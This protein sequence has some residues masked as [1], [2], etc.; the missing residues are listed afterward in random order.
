MDVNI[1]TKSLGFAILAMLSAGMSA[2]TYPDVSFGTT[3]VGEHV[4]RNQGLTSGTKKSK[5][6]IVEVAIN[7]Y[8]YDGKVWTDF[9]VTGTGQLLDIT[10]K[11]QPRLIK[12]F[13]L[14]INKR[15]TNGLYL[16]PVL[17][18]NVK[19]PLFE[20]HRYKVLV[21]ANSVKPGL[22]NRDDCPFADEVN[23]PEYNF[24]FEGGSNVTP[25]PTIVKINENT[26]LNEIGRIRWYIEGNYE[27][28]NPEGI[29]AY[30]D[31]GLT[32]VINGKPVYSKPKAAIS[33]SHYND[34]TY[35]LADF[36]L[37]EK[38]GEPRSMRTK[39]DIVLTMEEGTVRNIDFPEVVNGK[40]EITIKGE[41]YKEP[42]PIIVEKEPEYVSLSLNIDDRHSINTKTGKGQDASIG[43]IPDENWE[44]E[45]VTIN[46]ADALG[47]M[48][49]NG[50]LV[51]KEVNSD[52]TINAKLAYKGEVVFADESGIA[53]LPESNVSI[54]TDK[55]CIIIDNLKGYET[56]D[57]YSM[58]G[59]H[60][61]TH[62]ASDTILRIELLPGVYI[63]A[64]DKEVA[65]IIL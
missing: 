41:P 44:V 32:G 28:A 48:A 13:S 23:S 22:K 55:G 14:E 27:V 18:L 31:S 63:I 62:K 4:D 39:T 17:T 3:V 16:F 60:I 35:I 25:Q 2:Q 37:A 57:V 24:S 36:F 12:E 9:Q 19:E 51:L 45:S 58:A 20:G 26:L 5:L 49:D 30:Y 6:D 33:L 61:A 38:T 11:E 47:D 40:Y 65:K 64:V 56:V 52:K 10:D 21:P 15:G 8:E 53:V 34:R 59:Q 43:I 42:E 46:G 29:Y 1:L 54:F 7:D 50:V